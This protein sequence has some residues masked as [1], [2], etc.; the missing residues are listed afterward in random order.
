[1]K[2]ERIGRLG[3]GIDPLLVR[4]LVQVE[5]DGSS[6]F[7][8]DGLPLIAY[9]GH[10]FRRLTRCEK[11]D[12]WAGVYSSRN[13]IGRVRASGATAGRAAVW[14]IRRSAHCR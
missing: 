12:D 6:G 5:S 2:H 3:P 14:P 10:W 11:A 7:G 9:E 8:P 1:M 4:A 13:Y